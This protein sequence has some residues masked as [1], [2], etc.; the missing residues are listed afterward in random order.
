MTLNLTLSGRLWENCA[1]SWDW[2]LQ[3]SNDGQCVD[4][5]TVCCEIPQTGLVALSMSR[6]CTER[7]LCNI[8]SR[9]NDASS[10]LLVILAIGRPPGGPLVI[11]FENI[12]MFLKIE[13][14]I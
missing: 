9:L 8:D 13:N 5:C 6:G 3:N 11:V 14:S 10:G 4:G 7:S 12:M 2:N 1:C